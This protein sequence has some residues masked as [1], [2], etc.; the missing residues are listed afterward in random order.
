MNLNKLK[1]AS[2]WRELNMV[3][4][5]F[6]QKIGP[7][8]PKRSLILGA[9]LILLGQLANISIPFLTKFIIDTAVIGGNS[10][11]FIPFLLIFIVVIICI[12][13]TSIISNDVLFS[14]FRKAGLIFKNDMFK[15]FQNANWDIYKDINKG[16][17]AYLLV[18]DTSNVVNFWTQIF[19][20]VVLQSIVL[21]FLLF[22]VVW[23]WQ[24]AIFIVAISVA[25]ALLIVL[26]KEPMVA[27]AVK[28]KTK[29]QY[30]TRFL[31]EHFS[32]IDLVK[33]LCT[34]EYEQKQLERELQS[35]FE[36]NKS[37]FMV[38]KYSE[39]CSLLINNLWLFAIL[40]YGGS[41]VLNGSMTLGTLMAALLICNIIYKPIAM[42]T[43]AALSFQDVR[44][45]FR[46]LTEYEKYYNLDE[47]FKKIT[48]DFDSR[49]S[50][51]NCSFTYGGKN[52]IENV[53][54]SVPPNSIV[55]IYGKNG[56][57]KSTLAKLLAKFYLNYQGSI[58]INNIDLRNIDP[59]DWRQQ[60]LFC[61][62]NCH[63]K[64]GTVWENITYGIDRKLDKC[65]V[66]EAIELAD[67]NF[68]NHL[69][70]GH[71]TVI[72]SFGANIS[73]GEAQKLAL[74]RA[75]L[76]KPKILILD[77]ILSSVDHQSVRKI[78]TTLSRL[79]KQMTI[80]IISHDLQTFLNADYAYILTDGKNKNSGIPHEIF[81]EFGDIF[82]EKTE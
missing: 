57:G 5:I 52:A 60:V 64:N 42:L 26:F 50:I 67:A 54:L 28:V 55:S 41:S 73:G 27:S 43:S 16:D 66:L 46:R 14:T 61:P 69:P 48:V 77:E 68:I 80:I 82:Q 36:A 81:K 74:A 3:I 15:K 56:S 33:S 4:A 1:N 25:N 71:K 22:L 17:I 39:S 79:K 58:T 37:N 63:I 47:N 51:N 24:M 70:M 40:W 78:M 6:S 34:E 65:E 35:H 62:Q 2:L 29:A 7:H 31:V 59:K 45:S 10:Q 19:V 21:A 18:N 9:T 32:H 44:V 75:F 72:G 13:A 11:L 38:Q 76:R 23:N 49:I 8:I 53:S 12:A 20:S 30:I